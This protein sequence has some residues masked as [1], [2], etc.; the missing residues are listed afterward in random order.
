M[1]SRHPIE[2][3]VRSFSEPGTAAKPSFI[4]HDS[5]LFSGLTIYSYLTL[6]WN[7]LDQTGNKMT[8][9]SQAEPLQPNSDISSLTKMQYSKPVD[10]QSI[11]RSKFPLTLLISFY[12]AASI[13][14]HILIDRQLANPEETFKK[15]KECGQCF[16]AYRSADSVYPY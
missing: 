3:S 10:L 1:E 14:D 4:T 9:L 11:F 13:S 2:P 7:T 12:F 6:T 15:P 16:L 5:T 8:F